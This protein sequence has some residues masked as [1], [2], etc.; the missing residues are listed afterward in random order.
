MFLSVENLKKM[1]RWLRY[2][3]G[4]GCSQGEGE[5][6]SAPLSAMNESSLYSNSTRFPRTR[7]KTTNGSYVM[8]LLMHCGLKT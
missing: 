1:R 3:M 4:R 5:G 7:L 6:G 2:F 8:A